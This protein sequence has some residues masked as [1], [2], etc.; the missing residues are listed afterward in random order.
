MELTPLRLRSS[1]PERLPS[2]LRGLTSSML[3]L[4]V[5]LLHALLPWVV[6]T[7]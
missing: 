7:L 5:R 4:T 3:L 2:L 6:L 1:S